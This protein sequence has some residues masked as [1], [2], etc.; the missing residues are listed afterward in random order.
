MIQIRTRLCIVMA[1]YVVISCHCSNANNANKLDRFAFGSGLNF[2]YKWLHTPKPYISIILP[3]KI[4]SKMSHVIEMEWKTAGKKNSYFRVSANITK[5]NSIKLS[6]N[7]VI[8]F[9]FMKEYFDN[10]CRFVSHVENDTTWKN[11][12]LLYAETKENVNRHFQSCKIRFDSN[13]VVY[14]H[15]NKTIN[16]S[17]LYFEE[18]Y[19]I[20]QNQELLKRNL[21]GEAFLSTK[22]MDT[23]GLESHIWKRRRNLEGTNFKAIT[24]TEP[25]FITSIIRDTDS[26]ANSVVDPKGYYADI[27]NQLMLSL[28]F[29]ITTAL[30]KKRSNWTY[31]METVGS[32]QYDI[33]YTSFTLTRS[34]INKVDF[35]YG[36]TPIWFE[37]FYV[38][39]SKDINLGVFIR[40]FQ[41]EAWYSLAIFAVS[42][43]AGLVATSLILERRAD[44]S[45]PKEIFWN[46]QNATNFVMRS[47]IGKRISTEPKWYSTRIAFVTLVLCGF[48]IITLYRA[49]LVAFVAVENHS[50]PI[51]SLD[52]LK[53]SKYRLA[54]LKDS[55]MDA[56]FL[57]ATKGSEE[58]ELKTDKKILRYSIETQF[59]IEKMVNEE[60]E[61]S[62][63]ILFYI[64]TVPRFSK[65]Y[66]CRL[67]N[68]KNYKR[69]SK[70][71]I[72]MI[73]KKNWPFTKLLNYHLL[74]MKENG[75]LDHIF[76][77]Y[78][79]TTKKTCSNEQI[80]H[81]IITTPT[82]VGTDTTLSLY[83]LVFL[84]FVLA[85]LALLVEIFHHTHHKYI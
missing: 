22:E 72:G 64:N 44:L 68:I 59:F 48:F 21:L 55:N 7:E 4:S 1:L 70:Q 49:I 18:I 54:V 29:T 35:S 51:K 57:N 46:L 85:S 66:P 69:D 42:S 71:Q 78:L 47:V 20:H 32:G 74:I 23:F 61:A 10:I 84:G 15:F 19:K 43:I 31:F 5:I 3:S 52:D 82:P 27:M 60:D 56:M 81:S 36:I 45:I 14:Y 65:H 77:T 41:P 25:P 80:I 26:D 76:E 39:K 79:K 24:E 63:I 30:P 28:N 33:G 73:F 9:P 83:L 62:N 37:L 16:L 75:M 2:S 53:Q 67:S 11:N 6:Q 8:W 17:D 50:P 34:R 13:V 40:S 38:K 58:Y 12:F